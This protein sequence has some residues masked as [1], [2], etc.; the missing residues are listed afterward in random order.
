MWGGAP[1]PLEFLLTDLKTCVVSALKQQV[2][3]DM[4]MTKWEFFLVRPRRQTPA[5]RQLSGILCEWVRASPRVQDA[6][7][8]EFSV[9]G[10]RMLPFGAQTRRIWSEELPYFPFCSLCLVCYVL[11]SKILLIIKHFCA[12]I[13]M[14]KHSTDQSWVIYCTFI[15]IFTMNVH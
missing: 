2:L 7:E 15:F 11:I 12:F 6:A 10:T 9:S 8:D 14:Y 1:F 4:A 3:W 13:K 5:T